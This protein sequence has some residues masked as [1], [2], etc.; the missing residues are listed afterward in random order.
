[1]GLNYF[2]TAPNY[3]GGYSH[4]ILNR[5]AKSNNIFVD[6]KY[7]QNISLTP[8][9]I[10]KRIYRFTNFKSFKQSFKY[11]RFNKIQRNNKNFWSIQK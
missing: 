8:K 4:Y 6:T 10:A 11:I 1:M 7:G 3:G 5:L 9:E 2:D